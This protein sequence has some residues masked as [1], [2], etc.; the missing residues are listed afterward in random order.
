MTKTDPSN[1]NQNDLIFV[2]DDD[3]YFKTKTLHFV[4]AM[5]IYF[6]QTVSFLDLYASETF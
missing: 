3:P 4:E 5:L 1:S 6:Y 2:S